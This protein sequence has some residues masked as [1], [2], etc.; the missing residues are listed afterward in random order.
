MNKET[1]D[2]HL[3]VTEKGLLELPGSHS[4][5]RSSTPHLKSKKK[6]QEGEGDDVLSNASSDQS[7]QSLIEMHKAK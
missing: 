4:K 6:M 3:G 5:N 2:P 7:L 1:L